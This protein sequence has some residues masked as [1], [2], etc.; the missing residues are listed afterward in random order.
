MQGGGD[1]I[2]EY[3]SANF[4][5]CSLFENEANKGG[6]AAILGSGSF[7]DCHV[8]KNVADLSGGGVLV[9]ADAPYFSGSANFNN[10]N[11]FN[12]SAT[13]SAVHARIRTIPS[14]RSKLCS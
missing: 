8:Y 5:D 11:L 1:F 3:A 9:Q 2:H 14:P 13:N 4:I 12:N 10:C 6:G 7:T